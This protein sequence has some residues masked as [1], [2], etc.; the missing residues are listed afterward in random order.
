MFQ[1]LELEVAGADKIKDNQNVK[2]G[3]NS[4]YYSPTQK[5]FAYA[6]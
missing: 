2:A 6:D 5:I 4:F 3:W 1:E